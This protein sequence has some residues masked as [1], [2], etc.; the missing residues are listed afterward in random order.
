MI[1]GQTITIE[2]TAENSKLGA[3]VRSESGQVWID[4]LAEWPAGIVGQNVRATG[5]VVECHD[6]P[7]F[8]RREG[9]PLRSGIPVPAGTDLKQ[10]SLRHLLTGAI[11][12][13]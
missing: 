13:K 3:S 9:E 7:V 6:L 10:A 8:I 5:T 4:G 1:N 2:G 11:W 12:T